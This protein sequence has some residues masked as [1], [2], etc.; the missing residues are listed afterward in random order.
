MDKYI[1]AIIFLDETMALYSAKTFDYTM[2]N[3]VLQCQL[4]P[5]ITN[6]LSDFI[7]KPS[8]KCGY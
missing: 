4:K 8:L 6:D 3:W 1:I 5:L 7:L 2:F